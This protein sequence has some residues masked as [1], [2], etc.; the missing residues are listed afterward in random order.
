[1][2]IFLASSRSFTSSVCHQVVSVRRLCVRTHHQTCNVTNVLPSW[3]EMRGSCLLYMSTAS[4]NPT[5]TLCIII[6]HYTNTLSGPWREAHCRGHKYKMSPGTPTWNSA[7][8]LAKICHAYWMIFSKHTT[9]E[10]ALKLTMVR[11]PLLGGVGSTCYLAPA[12]GTVWL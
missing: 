8:R 4:M 2:F 5:T 9:P 3:W 10:Y 7:K 6:K 1:M 12:P 11:F